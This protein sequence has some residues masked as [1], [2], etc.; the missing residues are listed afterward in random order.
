MR[1][2]F[3]NVY[4]D[5]QEL[6]DTLPS[7]VTAIPFGW[8]EDIEEARNKIIADNSLKVSGLPSLNFYA[9]DKT[10]TLT[11]NGT[12]IVVPVED[13]WVEVRVDLID[14]PWTW[15]KIDAE[16]NRRQ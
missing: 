5:A 13:C 1:Y 4:G 14:K 15:E 6:I 8:S 3:Y 11:I 2:F 9:T 7:D 12:Q 16:I 10:T